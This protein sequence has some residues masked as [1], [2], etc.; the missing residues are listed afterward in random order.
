MRSL[1]SLNG[2][3]ESNSNGDPDCSDEEGE[4]G[5]LGCTR[6]EGIPRGERTDPT[7]LGTLLRYDILGPCKI[8]INFG[9]E[10]CFPLPH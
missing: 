10:R 1:V 2:S 7:V 9:G 5:E 3:E 4:T 8:D 6:G